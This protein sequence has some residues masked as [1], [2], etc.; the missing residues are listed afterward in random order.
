MLGMEVVKTSHI[1]L[2]TLLELPPRHKDHL[3]GYVALHHLHKVLHLMP[4]PEKVQDPTLLRI[5]HQAEQSFNHLPKSIQI[6]IPS[7]DAEDS[8]L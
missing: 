8:L 1:L 6:R 3:V 4:T 7:N 5:S 2:Q